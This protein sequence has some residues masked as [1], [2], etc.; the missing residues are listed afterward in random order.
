MS[1]L[2]KILAFTNILGIVMLTVLGLMVYA[3]HREWKYANYRYDIAIDGLPLHKEQTDAQGYLLYENVNPAMQKELFPNNPVSTQKEEVERVQKAL[4]GKINA[5]SDKAK[6]SAMFATFLLPLS[7]TNGERERRVSIRRRLADD[8]TIA[9]LKE[10]FKATYPGAVADNQADPK[11]EVSWALADRLAVL[12]GEPRRPFEEKFLEVMKKDP[13]KGFD[14]AFAEM[15]DAVN[16][17]LKEQFDHEFKQVLDGSYYFADD[18]GAFTNKKQ[19]TDQERKDATATLLFNLVEAE[20]GE[21]PP[22]PNVAIHQNAAYKRYINVVGLAAANRAISNQIVRLSQILGQLQY[23]QS[24]D[25]TGF[26]ST[27]LS[28]IDQ[29]KDSARTVERLDADLRREKKKVRDLEILVEARDKDVRDATNELTAYRK[30]TAEKLA[31]LREMSK[32]V[33][34]LRVEVRDKTVAIQDNER[35]IRELEGW[36]W[37]PFVGGKFLINREEP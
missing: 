29:S 6:Q 15:L 33:F 34:D 19:M 22:D 24:R 28:I 11:K 2:G 8:K 5:Q 30:T 18:K 21:P 10:D 14:E 4:Q 20:I 31:Q 17:D 13:A 32:A 37:L 35:K 25:Q 1:Y 23:E 16:A 36:R 7:Q 26:A 27:L 9:Q 3:K 12:G